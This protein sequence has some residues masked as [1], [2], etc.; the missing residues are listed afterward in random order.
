MTVHALRGLR[1][2][3]VGTIVVAG[4]GCTT[5]AMITDDPRDPWEGTNRTFYAF[6]DV[7]DQAVLAPVADLYLK[8][9][10]GLRNSIHN[11][12]DNAAYPG[13][14]LNQLLQAK[15]EPAMEGTA[16]FVFNTTLG[17]GGLFDVSTGFGLER[18]DEDFGQTLAVW[19]VDEGNYINYPL[20]GPSTVRDTPGIVVGTLTNV[21]TYVAALPLTLLD[22]VDTRANLA[23]AMKIRDEYAF[24][25]YVFTREAYRQRRTYLIHDGNPPVDAF[26]EDDEDLEEVTAAL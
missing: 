16:R 15:F 19:G 24:D 9:P 22:I 18:R 13:T 14:V 20:L 1:A 23:S 2:L 6:N 10:D 12:L 4:S 7:I 8:L 21:L 26:D 11:F 3:V 5:T 17:I 25:P